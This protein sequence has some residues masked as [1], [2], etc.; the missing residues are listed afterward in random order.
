MAVRRT[1]RER[2]EMFPLFVS[3][4]QFL[5]NIYYM[6]YDSTLTVIYHT[7]LLFCVTKSSVF[8]FVISGNWENKKDRKLGRDV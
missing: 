5:A 1:L 2:E 7:L 4:R 8:V 3:G 6:E